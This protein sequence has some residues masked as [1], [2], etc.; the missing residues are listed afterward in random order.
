M[1]SVLAGCVQA[2]GNDADKCHRLS[3]VCKSGNK[4]KVECRATGSEGSFYANIYTSAGQGDQFRKHLRD[5]ERNDKNASKQ[6]AKLC[7]PVTLA[8]R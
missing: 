3:S 8:E 1:S 5:I 6:F 2:Q 7:R 4:S